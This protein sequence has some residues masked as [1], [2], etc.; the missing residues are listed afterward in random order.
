MTKLQFIQWLRKLN[1]TEELVTDEV[2]NKYLSLYMAKTIAD[3]VWHIKMEK[4][5]GNDGN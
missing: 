4:A 1:L 3:E 2:R 5:G